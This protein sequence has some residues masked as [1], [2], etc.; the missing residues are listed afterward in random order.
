MIVS[1]TAVYSSNDLVSTTYSTRILVLLPPEPDCKPRPR[2]PTT[3]FICNSRVV[4]EDTPDDETTVIFV[5]AICEADTPEPSALANARATAAAKLELPS[6]CSAVTPGAS[7]VSA[8]KLDRTAYVTATVVLLLFQFVTISAFEIVDGPVA[9]GSVGA[10]TGVGAGV[11]GGAV[12]GGGVEGTNV[13]VVVLTVVI[14][15]VVEELVVVLVD[16][17]GKQDAPMTASKSNPE[18]QLAHVSPK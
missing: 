3:L 15:M 9:A 13:V 1:V 12:T 17:V 18:A 7:C 4:A 8:T 14:V 6:N 2:T 16:E 10:G 5:I 11:A